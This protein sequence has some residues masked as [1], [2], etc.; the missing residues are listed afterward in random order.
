MASGQACFKS[1]QRTCI[2]PCSFTDV[3]VQVLLQRND[4]WWETIGVYFAQVQDWC[5][6]CRTTELTTPSRKD[7]LAEMS[8]SINELVCVDHMFLESFFLFHEM[9][10]PTRFSSTELVDKTSM[11]QSVIAFEAC[12]ISQFWSP[13]Y[14][15]GKQAFNTDMLKDILS[16][17]KV[18]FSS[19]PSRRYR[20]TSLIPNMD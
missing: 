12:W 6:N 1:R 16:K 15:Q 20:K 10:V 11:S 8:R 19:L 4:L 18:Q 2:W 3:Q 7:S 14:V 17:Y 13:I 9:Y 5:S